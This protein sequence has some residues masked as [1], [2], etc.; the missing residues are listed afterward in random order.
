MKNYYCF[1]L[2]SLFFTA[3]VPQHKIVYVQ[4]EAEK[5]RYDYPVSNGKNLKIEP[6]DELY[7]SIGSASGSQ[8]GY[9]FFN[10]DKQ[11]FSSL[12]EQ[13][14]TVLSYTVN[15]SGKINLPVIGPVLVRGRTLREA[16]AILRDSTKDLIHN[17]I[18][19][20]RF[21]NNTITLLGEVAKAGTYPYPAE[22]PNI[23]YALG[24]AGDITEYGNRKKVV[25]IR[26]SHKVIHKYCLDLTQDSLFKSDLYYLR[27]RDV[28]YVE[29]LRIRR[30]GMKEYP[31]SLV[32][33]AITSAFLILFYIK[34]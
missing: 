1:V 21:V 33:T 8:G 13:A 25:L 18:V 16:E 24:L 34:K 27:P 26:E 29:P 4:S 17:P 23:F 31:F 19:S 9:N 10:Q 7:I 22:R 11:N 6:F 5:N 32:V 15:D 30:F 2:I 28:I 12:S 14:L 20:V 3:C